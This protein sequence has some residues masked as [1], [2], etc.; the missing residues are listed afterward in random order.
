MFVIYDRENRCNSV[1][2]P[3]PAMIASSLCQEMNEKAGRCRYGI[4]KREP[5][6]ETIDGE[7]FYC[8]TVSL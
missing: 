8:T 3:L 1:T 4:D 6:F 7:R 2:E 5:R